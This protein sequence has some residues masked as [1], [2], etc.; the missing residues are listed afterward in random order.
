MQMRLQPKTTWVEVL[1][2]ASSLNAESAD[3]LLLRHESGVWLLPSPFLPPIQ[4][5][6]ADAVA[7]LLAVLKPMF[8]AMIIDLS[9]LDAA[10]R[11][12]VS[13]ADFV[14]VTLSP[15]VA[16]LQTTAATLR[17]L[18]SVNIPDEKILLVLNQVSPK[19]GLSGAA[20]EK[21]LGRPLTVSVPY[22]DAQGQALAQGTP[23]ALSQSNSALA[24]TVRQLIQALAPAK[25]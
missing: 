10:G 8:G 18:K 19:P 25:A 14:A 22:D 11:T 7:R 21:A 5:P 23:L 17:V 20:I 16:S 13:T 12:V 2:Q 6:A 3:R 15:E 9:T 1:A 4:P 24:L